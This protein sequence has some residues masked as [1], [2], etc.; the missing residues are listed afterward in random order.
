M[1]SITVL[2]PNDR[3]VEPSSW[4]VYTLCNDVSTDCT[5]TDTD[6][7]YDNDDEQEDVT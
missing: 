1:K 4:R 7:E 6:D 3:S 2:N 5:T